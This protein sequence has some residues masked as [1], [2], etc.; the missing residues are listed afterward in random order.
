LNEA[1]MVFNDMGPQGMD[2][3]KYLGPIVAASSCVPILAD[4]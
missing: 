2:Y 4:T 3:F 1:A